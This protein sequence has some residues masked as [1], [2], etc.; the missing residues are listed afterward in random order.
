[1][2]GPGWSPLL[3]AFFTA[4]AFLLLTVK[5]TVPAVLCGVIAVVF[6][7]VWLWDTDP[8]PNHPPVDIGGG[9][10]LPVYVTGPTSH[11]WWGMVVLLLVGGTLFACLLFSYFFLWTVNPHQWAGYAFPS[12]PWP[13]GVAA[14]YAASS[15]LIAYAGY[16]LR[17]GAWPVRLALLGATALLVLALAIDIQAH[18]QGGLRPQETSHAAVVATV[19]G[20]QAVYGVTLVIMALYTLARSFTG[21]LDG[22]RRATYD[23]TMLLWHF[24]V[25]QGLVGLAVVHGFPRLVGS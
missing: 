20:L 6:I 3:S 2:P 22:I 19:L 23:N 17:R 1:M 16:A 25:A 12:A 13:L 5:L 21:K 7:L 24:A 10:T 4:A 11:S 9:I 14:L 18:R 15:G 8:G